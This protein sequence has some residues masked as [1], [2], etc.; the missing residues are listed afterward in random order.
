MADPTPGAVPVTDQRPIPRGALPRHAQTWVMVA[1]AGVMLA[2]IVFTGHP[3]P[4]RPATTVMT[5]A[6]VPNADR[7]KEY[8]DRLRELDARTRELAVSESRTAPVATRPTDDTRPT[9][10][11]ADPLVAERQRRAYDS[12]FASTIVLSRRPQA[13][14]LTIGE[15]PL[16]RPRPS[17][18]VLPTPPSIDDV[19]DAVVRATSRVSP[20]GFPPASLRPSDGDLPMSSTPARPSSAAESARADATDPIRSVGPL[21]RVLEGT[22]IE[23][24]LTNRL[25]GSAASPVNCLVTTPLYSHDGQH[26]LIPSG[27]RVLGETKPVQTVGDSRLAV[28]FHRVVLPDGSTR[29]L[30][31]FVG[32]N[33]LGDAGLHDQV[34]RHY[35]STFG[36]SAAIGLITGLAQSLGTAGFSRG[37]SDRSLVIV[38][39]ASDATAQ[40]TAQ[41]MNRFLNRLPTITIRE[42]HRIKIYV[43]NDLELPAYGPAAGA[44]G[45]GVVDGARRRMP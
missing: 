31:Q 24:V 12:L 44:D 29:R 10:A 28:A 23:T 34:N 14:R 4:S 2:I 3:A 35:R 43:T 7:L 36:A 11:A 13:Q 9:R 15:G 37:T 45:R 27:A 6:L 16:A 19:A 1:V 40:A 42:G 8:Q 30:D 21:H 33:D 5:P 18:A 38:G 22:V 25:D 32:L 26:V 41:S 39:G 20:S 17:D